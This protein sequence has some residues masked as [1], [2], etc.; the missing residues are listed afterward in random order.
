MAPAYRMYSMDRDQ[1]KVPYNHEAVHSDNSLFVASCR[2]TMYLVNKGI[3]K[4]AR[5]RNPG[6]FGSKFGCDAVPEYTEI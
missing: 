6:F 5:P 3:E 2:E 4:R 1:S